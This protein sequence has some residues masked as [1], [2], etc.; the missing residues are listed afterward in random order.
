MKRIR[1]IMLGI[2][3]IFSLFSF[4]MPFATAAKLKGEEFN[5][6]DSKT[7][8]WVIIPEFIGIETVDVYDKNEKLKKMDVILVE[9]PKKHSNNT[10]PIFEVMAK[11]EKAHMLESFPHSLYS[12]TLGGFDVT[13]SNKSA[14]YSVPQLNKG[15]I[16]RYVENEIFTFDFYIMNAG[17]EVIF[18]VYDLNFMFVQPNHAK[19][20][21]IV[22]PSVAKVMVDG[23]QIEFDAFNIGGN[24]YFKLRDVAAAVSDSKK[25]F[26]I[27]WDSEKRAV[28]LLSGQPY[29]LVGGELETVE[30]RVSSAAFLS[31]SSIYVD[32]KPVELAAYQLGG[33]NYF[34]LRDLAEALNFNVGWDPE[35][36]I[37]SIDTTKEY[38]Q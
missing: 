31:K 38:K 18:E 7:G 13:F 24:N 20:V 28:T 35:K 6:I 11:D 12:G 14:I 5:L 1:F 9:T 32:G 16:D 33:S 26:G 29:K 36:K 10:Y 4:D 34:K 27:E 19:D 2:V 37:V 21:K 3:A 25:G 15:N 30:Q 8:Y 17:K 22:S 23:K